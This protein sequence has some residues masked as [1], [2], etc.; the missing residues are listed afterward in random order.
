[1]IVGIDPGISGAVAWLSSAGALVEVCDLPVA[2]VKVGKATRRQLMP[3]VLA[4]ML[5]ARKP[6]CVYVEQV[7]SHP[8]EGAVGA[9]AF[10]RGFGQIEG[11]L[12]GLGLS[13]VLVRP[14]VWKKAIGIAADKGAA[15]HYAARLWPGAADQF[16]RVKD[17]GR[18]E[19]GLI[20]LY[21]CRVLGM[22]DPVPALYGLRAPLPAEKL[23]PD[24]PEPRATER[25]RATSRKET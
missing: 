10:G 22:R 19:A 12:C 1:M 6:L 17:D 14:Q 4:K 20:G 23:I 24:T 2:E 18:A 25:S 9:F 11:I 15:R 3:A 13:Y 8:G 7:G 16:R 5:H 21:G